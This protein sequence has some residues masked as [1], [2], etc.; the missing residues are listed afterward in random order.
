MLGAEGRWG[1]SLLSTCVT[2]PPTLLLS[3]G[4]MVQ[5]FVYLG[6]IDTYL[7]KRGH[8]VP[9]SWKLQ[10]TKQL[11]YALNYLVSVPLSI[12]GFLYGWGNESRFWSLDRSSVRT[13]ANIPE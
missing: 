2:P 7:R 10:V 5:E 6:A 9:A 3:P 11:A 13:Q 1:Q 8:L 4:I 12:G